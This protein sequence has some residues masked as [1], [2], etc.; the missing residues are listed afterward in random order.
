MQSLVFNPL[1]NAVHNIRRLINDGQVF[2]L[3]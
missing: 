3:F 1:I 2:P